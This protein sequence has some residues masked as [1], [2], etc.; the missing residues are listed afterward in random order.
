[1]T[2]ATFRDKLV[3][4]AARARIELSP[5]QLRQLETYLDLLTRW[6]ARMNLTALPLQGVPDQTM[7]RLFIEPL[8]A[9]RYV[10]LSRL[11]WIDIGSGGGSPA[12]PLKVL[13]PEA[14]LTMVESKGRK[15]AF[16]REAVRTLELRATGVEARRFEE[17]QADASAD[18]VTARAVRIDAELLKLCRKALR[19]GGD[20]LLFRSEGTA[21]D[22]DVSG[23]DLVTNVP[24]GEAGSILQV[25][26]V[27]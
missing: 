4:R 27:A 12:I 9:S 13:R 7:D 1:M 19:K 2:Q 16:L 11:D 5:L 24:L 20:L 18:V 8:L 3:T 23:F 25:W 17:L 6:N 22:A 10:Q 26:R 15:A 21:T 14:T